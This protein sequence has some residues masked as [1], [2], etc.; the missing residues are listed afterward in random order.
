MRGVGR[1]STV[2]RCG[3][4]PRNRRLDDAVI[5][6]Q[7]VEHDQQ[8]DERRHHLDKAVEGR[9]RQHSVERED[10]VVDHIVDLGAE[11]DQ[12]SPIGHRREVRGVG[13]RIH[14]DEATNPTGVMPA[15]TSSSQISRVIA[16]VVWLS[17]CT[18]IECASS[19]M[20]S[21]STTGINPVCR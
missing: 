9:C 13:R 10:S 3:N 12:Q 16:T 5:G 17:P 4:R 19:G 1:C 21:P 18:Q 6:D 20:G 7:R 14:D 11:L 8:V 15:A 2:V